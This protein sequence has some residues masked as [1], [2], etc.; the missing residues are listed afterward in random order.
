[1]VHDRTRFFAAASAATQE[2]ADVA[3]PILGNAGTSASTRTFLE[4]T[5]EALLKTNEQAV[6]Q[7]Q[8]GQMT[9]SGAELDNKLV[10]TEQTVVQQQLND[11]QG[12][13]PGAYGTAVK[14]INGLLNGKSSLTA[15]ALGALA[16]IVPGMTDK[17]YAGVLSGVRKSLGHDIDFRNQGDREAIGRALV[18]HVRQPGGC[19][20]A[21]SRAYGC[22]H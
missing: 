16:G 13:D 7:I 3:V 20:V 1:M 8:S 18:Q 11:L 12:K 2:L 6:Q 9:G 22:G 10:H 5:G 19:D 4:S 15:N 14:E 17:A 21:G